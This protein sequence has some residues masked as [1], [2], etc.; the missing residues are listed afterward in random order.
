VDARSGTEAADRRG[1]QAPRRSA[2]ARRRG[3]LLLTAVA[4][5]A[6][7][8]AVALVNVLAAR[9]PA[10]LDVTATADQSLSPRTTRILAR[11]DRPVRIVIAADLRAADA[12]V[13]TR[14]IDTLR[15]IERANPKVTNRIIDV[16]RD[17]GRRAFRETVAELASRDAGVLR[18]QVASIS[19]AGGSAAAIATYLNDHVSGSILMVRDA[20]PATAPGVDRARTLLEEAAG[21]A[22]VTARDLSA[23]ATRS[24]ELL[25]TK[26]EGIDLP[27]TDQARDQLARG[28]D[29]AI[30]QMSRLAA[31][32]RSVADA[33]GAAGPAADLARGLAPE[34]EQRRDQALVVLESLRSLRRPDVLRVADAL[35]QGAAALLIADPSPSGGAGSGSGAGGGGVAGAGGAG[36]GSGASRGSAEPTL[37]AID[38]ASLLPDSAWID[39][40]GL[41]RADLA[42]RSEELVSSALGSLVTPLRPVVV[43]TH[44][45]REPILDRIAVFEALRARLTLRGVDIV[46]WSNAHATPMPSLAVVDPERVRPLVFAVLPPDSSAAAREGASE[47]GLQRATGLAAV[48]GGLIDDGRSVLLSVSPSIAPSFGDQDPFAA[49]LARFGLVSDSGRPLVWEEATAQGRLVRSE[50]VAQSGAGPGAVDGGGGAGGGGGGGGGEHPIAGAIRGL[51]TLLPWPIALAPQTPPEGV[52]ATA[53]P[54]IDLVP[55]AALWA[56]SQ[57]LGYWQTPAAQRARGM[58]APSFDA[59][60][61]LREPGNAWSALT[62]RPMGWVVA[63]AAERYRVGFPAQR[64]VVVGANGWYSDAV[65][66]AQ[67]DLDGRP[68]PAFPGNM[69][70]TDASIAWLA[71]QDDLI[72]QSPTARAAPIVRAL[73]PED[74]RNLRLALLAGFPLLILVVGG[75]LR[76]IRG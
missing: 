44:T 26:I 16:S 58:N 67:A 14:L 42:R 61:D 21:L 31:A 49:A 54:I 56:E 68:V 71:G 12:R 23:T 74:V 25:D 40:A 20:L 1:P 46:E 13:R 65:A 73:T 9:F 30:L 43:L 5:C 41:A 22:R 17:D 63:A 8:C 18:E 24:T 7:V 52:R 36:G 10:R 47:T 11:I 37:A 76:L 19:L 66:L 55:D 32:M 15:E 72:A 69:E 60:R 3:A 2:R 62:T 28:L 6:G 29:A 35:R 70:L 38:P 27:A 39:S 45:E 75:A 53:W 34:L 59:S 4:A 51:P 64:M 50:R 48:V 33:P 57:W